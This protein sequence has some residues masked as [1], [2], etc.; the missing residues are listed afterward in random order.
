MNVVDLE[1]DFEELYDLYGESVKMHPLVR[2]PL[3]TCMMIYMVHLTNQMARKAP[4]PNIDEIMRQNPDIARQL[5][6]ASMQAQTQ[7]MR[8]TQNISPPAAPPAG[9][10]KCRTRLPV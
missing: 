3:R 8:T 10:L 5:A 2:I 7:N 6:A 4:I 1:D 9:S